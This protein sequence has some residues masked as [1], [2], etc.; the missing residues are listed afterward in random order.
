MWRAE[1]VQLSPE[2]SH[3]PHLGTG[4]KANSPAFTPK[5]VNQNLCGGAQQRTLGEGCI[6]SIFSLPHVPS[7]S[8]SGTQHICGWI[9]ATIKGVSY[10]HRHHSLQSTDTSVCTETSHTL[11][12][13]TTVRSHCVHYLFTFEKKQQAQSWT[14][15]PTVLSSKWRERAWNPGLLSFSCFH[16]V[17]CAHGGQTPQDSKGTEPMGWFPLNLMQV[18]LTSSG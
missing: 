6:K 11:T 7:G 16:P 3:Q 4:W 12:A 18:L 15:L 5:S 17:L 1:L 10:S 14:T 13:A 8:S 2:P 9:R